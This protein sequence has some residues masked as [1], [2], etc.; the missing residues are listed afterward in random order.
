[1]HCFELKRPRAV[2]GSSP[3]SSWSM[4]TIMLNMLL[5]LLIGLKKTISIDKRNLYVDKSIYN[6]VRS[7]TRVLETKHDKNE[8]SG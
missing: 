3:H 6:Q 4:T 8:E 7:S 5:K 2:A 1:V